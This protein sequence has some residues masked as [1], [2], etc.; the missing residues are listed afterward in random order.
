MS[1]RCIYMLVLGGLLLNAHSVYSQT[2]TEP[3]DSIAFPEVV[4]LS[5][6]LVTGDSLLPVPY[7]NIYRTRD[8][9]GV[10]SN[11]LGFFT[12]PA[13]KGDTIM[14]SNVGYRNV[15]YVIPKSTEEKLLNIVQLIAPDTIKLDMA[16][17]YPWPSRENF[18]SEF[19]ALELAQTDLARMQKNL[20]PLEM[21]KRMEF[22]GPDAMSAAKYSM[23]SEA[24]RLQSMGT[25]PVIGLLNP[26]SWAQFL[27]ALRNGDLRRQ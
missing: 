6:V 17:V 18:A 15:T 1:F 27:S 12:L 8:N 9:T 26:A 16:D 3:S 14:F 23:N 4:Q 2:E 25:A 11:A 22:L 13:F 10:I 5:G 24:L 20:D 7:S 19:L 21:E